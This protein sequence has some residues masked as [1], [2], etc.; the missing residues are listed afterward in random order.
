MRSASAAAGNVT[1]LAGRLANTEADWTDAAAL[2]R[3]ARATRRHDERALNDHRESPNVG[4]TPRR[5][6]PARRRRRRS[7]QPPYPPARQASGSHRTFRRVAVKA[8]RRAQSS[9]GIPPAPVRPLERWLIGAAWLALPI[10]PFPHHVGS[11]HRSLLPMLRQPATRPRPGHG[12]GLR[13][14]HTSCTTLYL[15][16]VRKSS[17]GWGWPRID[18]RW[19]HKSVLANGVSRPGSGANRRLPI[20]HYWTTPV[21]D[22]ALTSREAQ[23]DV[24]GPGC[25]A[26]NAAAA[27]RMRSGAQQPMGR[28]QPRWWSGEQSRRGTKPLRG[29]SPLRWPV[30]RSFASCLDGCATVN[31]T[32]PSGR[33]SSRRCSG[34][35]SPRGRPTD[36]MRRRR[37]RP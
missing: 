22:A 12:Q 25:G 32:S 36:T 35:M 7:R 17:R 14:A 29:C 27:R 3:R 24:V 18:T 11:R 16:S 15:S 2:Y 21:R 30:A 26:L 34:S 5:L 4:P 8:Q 10:E 19:R 31:W 20:Q 28:S 33:A 37:G 1:A 9:A 13:G 6:A 23:A